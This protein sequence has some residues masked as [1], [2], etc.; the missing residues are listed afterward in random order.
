MR[1]KQNWQPRFRRWC[2][3]SQKEEG[4]SLLSVLFSLLPSLIHLVLHLLS[5]KERRT[6]RGRSN[7]LNFSYPFVIQHDKEDGGVKKRWNTHLIP[8]LMSSCCCVVFVPSSTIPF[9]SVPLLLC[10]CHCSPSWLYLLF[11]SYEW[12]PEEDD[13]H[14]NDRRESSLWTA[15]NLLVYLLNLYS[16]P[17]DLEGGG[18]DKSCYG[19][20]WTVIISVIQAREEVDIGLKEA[21]YSWQR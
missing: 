12:N 4:L 9:F 6:G 13:D 18:R 21:T 8:L 20:E 2:Q 17:R 3:W 19:M 14:D 7:K 1:R 16:F 11:F 15:I 10:L 5:P